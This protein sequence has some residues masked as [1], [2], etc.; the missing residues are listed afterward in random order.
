MAARLAY[1]TLLGA[2]VAAGVFAAYRGRIASGLRDALVW[3]LIVLGLVAV[4]GLRD[5]LSAALWPQAAVLRDDG[6]LE[7]RRARDGHFHM[8]AEVNGAPV[9]FLVDTGASGLVLTLD[10]AERA[11]I[12]VASLD[13]SR[14]AQTANG[15]AAVAPVRLRTLDAAGRSARGVPALVGGDGLFASLMG[16]DWL[17]GY[18]R[19]VVEGD[20]MR[21]EP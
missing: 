1:L 14:R 12:D 3:G 19:V 5:D 7:L 4:Y 21:L 20:R 13:F 16:M 11:G 8:T 9:R 2:A 6:V 18:R 10:D 17:G 15:T